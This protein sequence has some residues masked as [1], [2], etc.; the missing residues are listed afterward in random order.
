[1]C[2][3][4][5]RER[6]L[7]IALEYDRLADVVERGSAKAAPRTPN[8][9]DAQR[10]GDQNLMSVPNEDREPKPRGEAPLSL[11]ELPRSPDIETIEDLREP[12]RPRN[13]KLLWEICL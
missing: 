7:Q 1:M 12:T 3:P 2:S 10:S 6:M 5:L 13:K 8:V 9:G 4:E 11:S